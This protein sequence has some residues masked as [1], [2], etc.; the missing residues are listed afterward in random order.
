MEVNVSYSKVAALFSGREA[1]GLRL[2]CF[3]GAFLFLGLLSGP[4]AEPAWSGSKDSGIHYESRQTAEPFSIHIVEANPANLTIAAERALG[5][6]IGRETV[7]SIAKRKRAIVAV[8][9][10]FFRIGGDY[11]G[12]PL[13]VLKIGTDWFSEPGL[14]RAALGWSE[15]GGSV[16]IDR[17]TMKWSLWVDGTV[18]PISGI[19]RPRGIKDSII[20]TG[21]F[22]G[23]TLTSSTGTEVIV[24]SGVVERIRSGGDSSI[25]QNGFVF[26]V[27]KSVGVELGSI[28][29]GDEAKV[30]WEFSAPG[31][32]SDPWESMEFLVGGTPLLLREGEII[33]DFGPEKVPEN[34]VNQRHPR[35]A[36]GIRAD[37]TWVFVVVDGRRPT[38]SVGMTLSELAQLMKSLGCKDALNL[39]GGGSS[40]LY[41][42]GQVVNIPSDLAGERPVSDA[43]LVM[44]K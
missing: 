34:F 24:D 28:R 6:G 5:K 8:N 4:F 38:I 19:N 44:P 14:P 12:E 17:L 22:N 18:F 7:S 31:Q 35:T 10:G 21:K 25:P 20:F 42:Y 36:V 23:S 13:G 32:P 41:L 1:C 2:P 39:D 15:G 30:S 33:R 16:L 26:S 43:I 11:D 40:T 3:L 29:P 9:G 37:G 27:G